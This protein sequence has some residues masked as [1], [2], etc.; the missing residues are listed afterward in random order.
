MLSDIDAVSGEDSQRGVETEDETARTGKRKEKPVRRSSEERRK[1]IAAV[2]L[3]LVAKQGLQ[4]TT[5]SRIAEQVG[6]EP[7]SLYAHFANRHEMLLAA[8]ELLF[9]R[10]QQS[11][12][13]SSNPNMLV[14]LQE[15]SKAHASFMNGE[16][17][18]FVIPIFEFITAPRDSGLSDVTG[19]NQIRTLSTIA[20]MV[21]EGKRQGTI[22]ADIDSQ[23]AAWELIVCYWAEDV[24]QLM[25]IDEYLGDKY[26]HRIID[27]MIRDMAAPE[28]GATGATPGDGSL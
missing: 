8:M 5:V 10:V 9:E 11:L 4:G 17:E 23:L 15:M 26:S 28:A 18:G 7:P 14:R 13:V 24:A 12:K 6:M 21:E 16:F 3:M 2:T 1:E 25:G 19:Q 27:L 22:R 20:N